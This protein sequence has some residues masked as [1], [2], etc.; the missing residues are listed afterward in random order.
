MARASS[1]R[2][3]R[4]RGRFAPRTFF[5]GRGVER[6]AFIRQNEEGMWEW[7]IWR[8]ERGERPPEGGVAFVSSAKVAREITEERNRALGLTGR[9]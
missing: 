9:G 3:S 5:S 2:S 1:W 4:S 7:D 8:P 6:T